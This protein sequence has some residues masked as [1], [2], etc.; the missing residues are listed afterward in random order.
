[1]GEQYHLTHD[2]RTGLCILAHGAIQR[3]RLINVIVQSDK[4]YTPPNP[5][6]ILGSKSQSRTIAG[7]M[8][9][10]RGNDLNTRLKNGFLPNRIT[11]LKV[12]CRL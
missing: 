12:K 6:I 1:M 4:R 9:E 7:V 5:V 3:K 2:Y 11:L 8:N 10:T